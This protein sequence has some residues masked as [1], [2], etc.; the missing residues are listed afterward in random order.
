MYREVILCNFKLALT[1]GNLTLYG[2]Y[3]DCAQF[4]PYLRKAAEMRGGRRLTIVFEVER[5]SSATTTV[6]SVMKIANSLALTANMLILCSE[7]DAAL[8]FGDDKKQQFIYV[9]GMEVDE[10]KKY[11]RKKYPVI[12]DQ[13]IDKFILKVGSLPLDIGLFCKGLVR[14]VAT[15]KLI[16]DAID[17]AEVDLL[18]FPHKPIL[19][20][21]KN[22]LEGV[23]VKDFYGMT[24]S[25]I[26]L[27]DPKA[28]VDASMKRRCP[29]MYHIESKEYRLISTAHKT[30]MRD[31][32]L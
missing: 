21:I 11:A 8:V 30:A 9:D 16:A 18:A 26:S 20:A 2:N 19:K 6:S 29:V 23:K 22:E 17:E 31:Y 25:G 4:Y 12:Q 3:T 28:M 15:D 14:G 24:S 13:D 10:A 32:E 27:S 1:F 5:A 7:I